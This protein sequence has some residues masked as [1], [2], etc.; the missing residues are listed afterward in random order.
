[1]IP[2][3]IYLEESMACVLFLRHKGMIRR[4]PLVW[5]TVEGI[6]YHFSSHDGF[7]SHRWLTIPGQ[8]F[9]L[10]MPGG[11]SAKPNAEIGQI[12]KTFKILAALG[13]HKWTLS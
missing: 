9:D 3:R 12:G 2:P 1:M 6:G 4:V 7:M 5:Y 10:R 8:N 13:S 11:D